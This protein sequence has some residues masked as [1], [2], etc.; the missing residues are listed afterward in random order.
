[1]NEINTDSIKQL[2]NRSAAHI[3]D[4]TLESLHTARARALEVHRPQQQAPVLA[5]LN[6]HG[7]WLGN[8]SQHRNPQWMLALLFAACL[9][10]GIIYMQNINEHEHDHSDIDIAILADDLPVD[11]YV[12]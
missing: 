7:L 4:S 3:D 1:M 2:L 6:H 12:E 9:F 5:W 11:A 10:G 8:H